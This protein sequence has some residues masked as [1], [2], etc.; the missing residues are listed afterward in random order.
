MC[1]N[2]NR[3]KLKKNSIFIFDLHVN[4]LPKKSIKS[5]LT[6][7]EKDM[8]EGLWNTGLSVAFF[9]QQGKQECIMNVLEHKIFAMGQWPLID[10]YWEK[11]GKNS[12][13]STAQE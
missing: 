9:F 4:G 1:H 12:S 10:V 5:D 13:Q 11:S 6:D 7:F 2:L 8:I 3:C